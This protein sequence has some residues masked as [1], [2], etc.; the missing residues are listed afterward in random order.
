[1]TLGRREMMADDGFERPAPPVR[2]GGDGQGGLLRWVIGFAA[3]AVFAASIWYAYQRGSQD[4]AGAYQPPLIKADPRP[5]KLRPDD[6]GGLEV[7]NRD[8][9]VY[10]RL[11]ANA[12]GQRVERLL[13]PPET[14][15]AKPAAPAEVT[16]GTTPVVPPAPVEASTGLPVMAAS[17]APYTWLAVSGPST[18]VG[19]SAPV[20][21]MDS[22]VI[23]AR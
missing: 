12:P 21:D 16:V 8:K 18:M 1:M 13:P 7:P 17:A 11:A 10:E 3:I 19:P 4:A 23:R 5:T 15:L 2:E 20:Q 14:P 22:A 6:P 9:L